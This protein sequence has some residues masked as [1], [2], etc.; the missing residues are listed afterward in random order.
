MSLRSIRPRFET[1]VV[2]DAADVLRLDEGAGVAVGQVDDVDP[3]PHTCRA[4]VEGIVHVAYE[5]PHPARCAE[6]AA[7]RRVGLR[8]QFGHA[9]FRVDA[10][11]AERF[12]EDAVESGLRKLLPVPFHTAGLHHDRVF[13]FS[14][15]YRS[16][17]SQSA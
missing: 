4:D 7:A 14:G 13:E 9:V 2:E 1:A 10:F 11:Y 12:A 15:A 16:A 8:G 6:D 17:R 3:A 5:H